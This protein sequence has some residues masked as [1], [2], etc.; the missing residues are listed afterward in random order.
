MSENDLINSWK[1]STVFEK[2]LEFNLNELSSITNYP[3]HWKI[4][5]NILKNIK[6]KS[7]LD[8]GCGCGSFFKVCKDNLP[9]LKYCGCDYSED[10]IN[11]AKKTWIDGCFF[12]K[13]IMDFTECDV[14]KYDVLYASAVLD[15]SPR[16]DEMLEKI[17]SLGV[18]EVV[19]SRVKTTNEDSY[20]TSYKAYD[21]I[22]TCAYYHNVKNLIS[23]F[24]KYNYS[25]EIIS[26]HIYLKLS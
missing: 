23:I 19:L 10:A 16:G 26:D 5:I 25:Y 14:D 20:Y 3:I 8:I 9:R 22:E 18:S 13:D 24:L 17:L 11:I 6:S 12:V 15:V 4:S 21:T 2:Q 1:N 7:L